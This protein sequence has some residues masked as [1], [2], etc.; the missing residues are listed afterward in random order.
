MVKA[1]K[2]NPYKMEESK[3]KK[4]I[5][6]LT[7]LLAGVLLFSLT[8]NANPYPTP[9]PFPDP[10]GI[11]TN[12]W[13]FGADLDD[14]GLFMH[15]SQVVTIELLDLGDL[16]LIAGA[17][18]VGTSFGFYFEGAD[19]TNPANIHNIFD[20]SD[21]TAYPYAPVTQSA[22]IDFNLGKVTDLDDGF[23]SVQSSFSG[24]GNIGFAITPDPSLGI[25]TLF[26]EALLNPG[27]IDVAGT[28]PIMGTFL[29]DPYLLTFNL[30]NPT[31]SESFVFA[32]H[33]AAGVTPV[34]EP[35]TLILL[36]G[37][38]AGLGFF[39]GRRKRS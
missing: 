25:P 20:V 11:T 6:T 14:P 21:L 16:S 38:L 39:R 30:T 3:M 5:Y 18:V 36:S 23:L 29:V 4:V 24:S 37:G 27:G 2:I 17:G 8:V 35:G 33:V 31:T 26:T 7:V 13:T 32:A 22:A 28:F 12:M 34:P 10:T 9:D 19:V 1:N 15:S